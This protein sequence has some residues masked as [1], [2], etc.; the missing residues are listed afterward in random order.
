MKSKEGAHNLKISHNL[1]NVLEG[2]CTLP[3]PE[4]R[5]KIVHIT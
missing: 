1:N 3:A 2:K 5:K 4:I